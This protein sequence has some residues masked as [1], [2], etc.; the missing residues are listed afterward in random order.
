MYNIIIKEY[1]HTRENLFRQEFEELFLTL[2]RDL[3]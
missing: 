3:L 2:E 1:L